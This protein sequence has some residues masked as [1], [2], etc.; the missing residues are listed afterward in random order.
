MCRACKLFCVNLFDQG[1]I[2]FDDDGKIVIANRLSDKDRD[3]L[4]ISEDVNILITEKNKKYLQYH[5]KNVF[6]NI[7]I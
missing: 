6:K 4:N 7:Q 1:L 2:T 3:V 5:R